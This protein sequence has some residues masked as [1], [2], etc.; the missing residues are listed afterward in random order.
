M[1]VA[2]HG[3]ADGF[4]ELLAAAKVQPNPPD[5][6][7]IESKAEI[8]KKAAEAENAKAEQLAKENPQL[9]LWKNIKESLTGADGAN[10]FNSGMK[11]AKLPALRGKVVRLEP[12]TKPKTI[13]LA[14][15][16]GST[17]DATLKFEMP[18]PGKVDP[19]TELSFEGQPDSYTASPFMVVFNV[20]KEDLHGWTGKNAPAPVRRPA[21]KKSSAQK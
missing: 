9:A 12:E 19:G 16:D 5:G 18:L 7:H 17:G 8:A 10:Y 4:T 3:K 11:G 14:L 15:E 13:V 20:E 6:F 2:L 1:Y 21:A